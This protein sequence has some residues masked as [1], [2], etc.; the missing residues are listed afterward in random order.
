MST[1]NIYLEESGVSWTADGTIPRPND[2]VE[3]E[4]VSTQQRVRL[5]DGS[6]AFVNLETKTVKEPFTMYFAETT[7]AFRTKIQTYM[8]NGDKVKIITHT[9]E[10]FIGRFV[11]MKRIWLVGTSPDSYDVMITFQR[12]L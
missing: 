3:T 2:D 9:L 12:T 1:W 7:S 4:T 10:E 5:A 8:G 11:S 6:D